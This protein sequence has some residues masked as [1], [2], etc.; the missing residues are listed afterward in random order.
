MS[1]KTVVWR[2]RLKSVWFNSNKLYCWAIAAIA[3]KVNIIYVN[4]NA[5]VCTC[6]LLT[7]SQNKADMFD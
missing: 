6:C 3:S 7:I 5:D 1:L 4:V 2:K